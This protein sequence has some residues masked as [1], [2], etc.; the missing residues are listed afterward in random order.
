MPFGL[1]KRLGGVF[2]GGPAGNFRIDQRRMRG[3]CVVVIDDQASAL[4]EWTRA[5]F[6]G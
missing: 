6:E 4:D 5:I 1:E 3:L 2:T